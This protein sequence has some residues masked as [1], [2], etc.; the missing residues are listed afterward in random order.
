MSAVEE[1]VVSKA[2]QFCQR[3][4]S[5]D[6]DRISKQKTAD[7]LLKLGAKIQSDIATRKEL[8]R[9]QNL[10][11]LNETVQLSDMLDEYFTLDETSQKARMLDMFAKINK[12]DKIINQYKSMIDKLQEK[13]E[14][15][16]DHNENISEQCDEY[17]L[18]L[19]GL[20]KEVEV[21]K[22]KKSDLEDVN[23]I[24][25]DSI[26]S[27]EATI[28]NIKNEYESEIFYLWVKFYGV[29]IAMLLYFYLF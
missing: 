11:Q 26:K 12:Q 21:I 16:K 17:M 8:N 14:E 20:E 18:E 13:Y 2:P 15:E 1:E 24:L 10:V 22:C 23:M 29:F 28:E 19:E 6:V 27:K 5:N 3:V 7:E 9:N 25:Q 4:D